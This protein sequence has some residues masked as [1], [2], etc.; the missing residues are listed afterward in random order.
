MATTSK[1]ALFLDTLRAE[2]KKDATF[3]VR[4][5]FNI[6]TALASNKTTVY[7]NIITDSPS[8]Q[9]AENAAAY[10]GL[11]ECRL[12]IYAIRQTPVDSL[13]A[14]NDAILHGEIVERI[15]KRIDAIN[16]TFPVGDTTNAGYNVTV[17]SC[18]EDNV[19]GYVS[20]GS[21]AVAVLYEVVITYVQS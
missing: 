9:T 6:E 10:Y 1:F 21:Q 8:P 15:E 18:R 3:D 2:L 5:V 16:S 13:D 7:V 4:K 19:T 20:D 14:G 11:R 17:H 12:G